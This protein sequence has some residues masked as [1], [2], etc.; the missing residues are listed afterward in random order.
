[1]SRSAPRP[2]A[3][4]LDEF[5][6]T[7]APATVLG[8]VQAAWELAVGPEVAAAARPT[9]ERQGTLIVTCAAAVWAQELEL[10]ACE[11]L[12]RINAALGEPLIDELRCRT[13]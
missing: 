9:R 11:L 3:T 6:R 10:M 1:M 8:R 2:I 12:P 7:L 5:T 13:V 4:A